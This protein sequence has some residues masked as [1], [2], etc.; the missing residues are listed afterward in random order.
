MLVKRTFGHWLKQRRKMLDLTQ[1]ELSE[2]IGCAAVTL[3]KI[4]ADERQPSKQMAE[5]LA[6]Q[7]NLPIDERGVF[8]RFARGETA[9]Y[10]AP[11][12]TPFSSPNNLPAPPTV[13]IGRD[14]DA[15][16]ISKRL[17]QPDVRLLTLIGPPGIGKTRL[18]IQAAGE[19]LDDFPDG[20]FFVA[21]APITDASLVIKTI[22]DTLNLQEMGPQTPL[23][24]LKAFLHDKQTLL[25]LDNFEQILGAAPELASLLTACLSIKLLVTSRAPLRIGQERQWPVP[26]LAL[27]DLSHLPDIEAINQFPSISLF[28]ERAQ[29]VKPD[30]LLTEENARTV[31]A[32]C[33][34]LDGLPLAIELIAARVK[35]LPPS[36]LLKR[37][38]G[39]LMLQSDGLRDIEPRHRTLSAAIDWS[40]QLLNT[41]EQTLFRRLG[42]FVGGW[43]LEAAEAICADNLKISVLDGLASLLDKNF[44]K[45]EVDSS[46][47]ARF[48]MLETI[49]EYA[50]EQSVENGDFEPAGARHAYYFATLKVNDPHLLVEQQGIWWDRLEIEHDNFRA[51]LAWSAK[52]SNI[53]IG[54]KLALSLVAFWHLRGYLVEAINWLTSLLN[55]NEMGKPLTDA[56]RRLRAIA[57]DSLATLY[58]FQGN[59]SEAKPVYE[60][61]LDEMRNIGDQAGI[62]A[63]LQDYGMWFQFHGDYV[64]S[65]AMLSEALSLSKG[66]DNTHLIGLSL[67][68]LGT[69]A[70]SE[71]QKSRA[72]L[73]WKESLDYLRIS[74]NTWFIAITLANLAIEA[75]DH[76]DYERADANLRQSLGLLQELGEKWQTI[77]TLEGFACLAVLRNSPNLF[78]AARIFGASEVF[79]QTLSTPSLPYQ[80]QFYERGIAALRIH[81]D[82][83]T[84]ATALAEGRSMTLDEAVVYALEDNSLSTENPPAPYNDHQILTKRELE[85]LR[86]ISDGLNSREIAERLILGVETI[87]WYL[88]IIY[89]KLGVHSRSEA[90][91]RAKELKLLT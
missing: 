33:T 16:A 59:L 80:T 69:L 83:T 62:I 51:A 67:F 75:L 32:I 22:T 10:A 2:C 72:F 26:A 27:P 17:L 56:V 57:L 11:W 7:L 20:V 53:E 47:E 54:L 84:L 34:R 76:I 86:L 12:G 31:S 38:Y 4:E 5:L 85:I 29:A 52:K 66:I 21:L 77:H 1:E 18:A 30:F 45:Q 82:D 91:S 44:I 41:D 40:Y 74:N 46:G 9:E 89:G 23:E 87:R 43:S 88:K 90:I 68:F 42:V 58:I 3:R 63:V 73:L 6:E 48:I 15:A 19:V 14:E 70:F 64:T 13:L 71:K 8:V 28:I 39:R 49:K 65:S 36:A 60:K 78:R 79:R 24:R 35:L 25:V 61:S 37:L 50:L 55:D 81:L